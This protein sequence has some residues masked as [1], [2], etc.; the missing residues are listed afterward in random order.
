MIE[1]SQLSFFER[2]FAANTKEILCFFFYL[3]KI[4]LFD[5]T[6]AGETKRRGDFG[7]R[8]Q[9]HHFSY[10]ASLSIDFLV[11]PPKPTGSLTMRISLAH[12]GFNIC[13]SLD[14]F[15]ERASRE[16]SIDFW[17]NSLNSCKLQERVVEKVHT[18]PLYWHTIPFPPLPTPSIWVYE[19]LSP[20]PHLSTHSF[21]PPIS[22]SFLSYSKLQVVAPLSKA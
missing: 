4:L 21:P 12:L 20:P 19:T 18:Q 5:P 14:F 6:I 16:N 3:W 15:S 9:T 8:L 17:L 22:S 13:I 10:K 2:G 1:N 11:R 7:R